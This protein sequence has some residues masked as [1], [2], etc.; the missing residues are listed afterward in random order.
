MIA[1][2]YNG[3]FLSSLQHNLPHVGKYVTIIKSLFLTIFD[4]ALEQFSAWFFLIFHVEH[5]ELIFPIVFVKSVSL[6]LI[7][8]EL[9]KI[10]QIR[11]LTVRPWLWESSGKFWN[12]LFLIFCLKNNLEEVLFEKKLNNISH[13]F[14]KSHLQISYLNTQKILTGEFQLQ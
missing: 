12:F 3:I 4:K 11:V 8:Q 1:W 10:P 7:S 6:C 14:R 9:W 2:P 5:C 13:C